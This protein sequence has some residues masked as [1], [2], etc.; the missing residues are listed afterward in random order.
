MAKQI[1]VRCPPEMAAVLVDA[2]RW[3]VECNYP[4]GADECSIAAR[5]ALLG[6]AQRFERELSASGQ[7]A[8]SSRVRAFLCEAVNGYT[9]HLE[10]RDGGSYARRREVMIQ[11]CRGLSAGEGFA[12][13]GQRDAQTGP[14]A[15]S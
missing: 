15:S 14:E 5:D 8:Y 10:E 11:V 12:A 3:F 9:H 2:L 7:C 6:L 13:A 4:H 1:N